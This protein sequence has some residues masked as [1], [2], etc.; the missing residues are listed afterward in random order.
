M[1]RL[2][3]QNELCPKRTDVE[4]IL[5]WSGKSLVKKHASQSLRNHSSAFLG[6]TDGSETNNHCM[7]GHKEIVG[8]RC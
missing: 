2:R 5:I 6:I 4:Y 3:L 7:F 1:K 8:V